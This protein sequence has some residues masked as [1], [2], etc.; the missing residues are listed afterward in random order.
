MRCTGLRRHRGLSLGRMDDEHS[1]LQRTC[2]QGSRAGRL[3]GVVGGGPYESLCMM[4]R[5]RAGGSV[6]M[7][8]AE[9]SLTAA[10]LCYAQGFYNAAANRAY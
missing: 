2:V 1:S 9:E 10:E 3:P 7:A 5:L 4:T 8:K 6:D